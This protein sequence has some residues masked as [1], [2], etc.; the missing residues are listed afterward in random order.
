MANFDM[1]IRVAHHKAGGRLAPQIN[2]APTVLTR[3]SRLCQDPMAQ[4]VMGAKALYDMLLMSGQQHQD[5]SRAALEASLIK[6]DFVFTRIAAV[7]SSCYEPLRRLDTGGRRTRG[8][9]V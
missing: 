9:I 3:Q 8:S 2:D 7:G 1:S 5:D 6:E 4:L